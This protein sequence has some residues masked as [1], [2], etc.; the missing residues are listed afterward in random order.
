MQMPIRSCRDARDAFCRHPETGTLPGNVALG[1][2]RRHRTLDRIRFGHGSLI[3]G[4]VGAGVVDFD[5]N[6]QPVISQSG[7]LRRGQGAAAG[8]GAHKF[9]YIL[10]ISKRIQFS[11]ELGNLEI[12]FNWM[13]FGNIQRSRFRWNFPTQLGSLQSNRV[14][15]NCHNFAGI[16]LRNK[17]RPTTL[18]KFQVKSV[19][20]N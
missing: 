3:I 2:R 11:T 6:V 1:R 19:N 13:R 12:N 10:E 9:L 17:L 15:F 16:F 18:A 14:N 8:G 5:G 7:R 4:F 20:C